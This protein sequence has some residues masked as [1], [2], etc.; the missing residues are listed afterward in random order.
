MDLTALPNLTFTY[1]ETGIHISHSNSTTHLPHLRQRLMSGPFIR[2]DNSGRLDSGWQTITFKSWLESI[3]KDLRTPARS[4][5]APTV[6][7]LYSSG[8]RVSEAQVTTSRS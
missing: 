5:T 2:L 4:S 1:L 7:F 3:L 6:H 8:P